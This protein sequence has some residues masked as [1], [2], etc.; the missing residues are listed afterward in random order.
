MTMIPGVGLNKQQHTST[1]KSTHF[2]LPKSGQY[3]YMQITP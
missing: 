1:G 3:N 2:E